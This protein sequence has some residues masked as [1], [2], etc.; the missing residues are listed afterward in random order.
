MPLINRWYQMLQ[1]FMVR[2]QLTLEELRKRTNTSS[3]TVKNSIKLLNE[4]LTGIAEI[5]QE[6]HFYT[7]EIIDYDLFDT[8][9][10]G[11][12]KVQSDFNSPS[13]RIGYIIQQLLDTSD[14][15]LIDDLSQELEVSRGTVNN[16]LKNLKSILVNFDISLNGTPNRG[17]KLVGE[18]LNLRLLCLNYSFDYFYR[19]G[20]PETLLQPF[21]QLA[22]QW[23][24]D[25][26][27]Q[28]LW[29]KVII[30]TL[31]RIKKGYSISYPISN[32]LNSLE[33]DVEMEEFV[34]QLEL[35][36]SLSLGK[37]DL[38]F[39][40][41]PV[42][43]SY[44][45]ENFAQMGG[46]KKI[47]QQ[48]M[49]RI[50]ETVIVELNEKQIF[51]EVK[52][53]LYFLINRLIFRMKPIDLFQDEIKLNY[54]FAYQLS[55]IGIQ[56]LESLLDRTAAKSEISY[57]AIYFE[58]VL[59]NSPKNVQK[60]IAIV[61]LTGRGT[62]ALIRRQIESV[63]GP[64][65]K[66]QQFLQV[67]YEKIDSSQFF[68]VFTTVP[69]N[70]TKSKTPIIQI[71]NLFNDDWLR[72]EWNR[73]NQEQ[74][75]KLEFVDFHFKK[76]KQTVSYKE[77][78]NELFADLLATNQV[79]SNFP[80]RVL[81]REKNS[82]T[83]FGNGIAFPH[84][85]LLETERILFTLGVFENEVMTRD[86]PV[87]LVFLV[88]IPETVNEKNEDEL[89]QLY[90]MIFTLAAEDSCRQEITALQNKEEFRG[91]LK[92]KGIM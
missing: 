31:D 55:T 10:T 88:G 69:L 53:H 80:E 28:I 78:L 82:S 6:E 25:N 2:Q 90:D 35:G 22:K 5:I 44:F 40:L 18:E 84:A 73:I 4:Q 48:I 24:L 3:Q 36:Y 20:L 89:L 79:D 70:Q 92:R 42:N 76:F 23:K 51:K 58:L 68:A 17:L 37:Y 12:L 32:Y 38:E 85:M 65:V 71:T 45:D 15:V 66:I 91:F 63:L 74:L 27:N 86:G 46:L 9:L 14:Y 33:K 75:S 26:K 39:L 34:S 52:Q 62:A 30:L 49:E 19:K 72:S 43:I 29:E 7:L 87:E 21:K 77:S 16:D 50:H 81:A 47:F 41:F 59:R 13:K 61:C 1:L 67:D 54:P 8:I 57:L 60:E 11:S 83:V 64:Q 56:F